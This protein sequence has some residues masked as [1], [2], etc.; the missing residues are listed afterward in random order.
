M[1]NYINMSLATDGL[2]TKKHMLEALAI[3]SEK[4]PKLRIGHS[5]MTFLNYEK[6]GLVD[7]PRH[8]LAVNDR[9]WRFYTD[10][11]IVDNVNRI[12]AHKKELLLKRKV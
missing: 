8:Q 5:Y 7:P 9:N 2:Y 1:Y 3:A 6:N 4:Y 12:V 10:K 11:E